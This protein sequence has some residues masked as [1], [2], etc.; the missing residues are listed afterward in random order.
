MLRKLS[1]LL[2]LLLLTLPAMATDEAQSI[3]DGIN[4]KF[5]KVND[6]TAD[7]FMTFDIP[8]VK[9][10][11]MSGRAFYKKPNKFRIRAKGIFFLPKQNMAQQMNT[12]L[13]DTKSYTAVLSGYEKV[14]NTN[15]A[16]INVIPLKTDGELII[17]RLWID[18][19]NSLIM[20]S[21]ITTRNNGTVET[22]NTFATQQSRDLGLP[23][24]I[25]V[26]VETGKFKVPKMLA[27]DINKSS[28]PKN[29]APV[30]KYGTIRIDFS[31]YKINTKLKDAVFTEKD[32]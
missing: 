4:R 22:Y 1:G 7:A 6:Y 11:N 20:H 17:S 16:I 3:I 18:P 21:Q 9:L 12:L 24:R 13:A 10:R 14:G 5:G 31:N 27:A 15:C 2:A 30:P 28:T 8:G 29:K 25:E 32:E 23:S 19:A 26:R